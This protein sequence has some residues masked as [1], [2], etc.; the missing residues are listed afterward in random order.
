MESEQ[1][2][3]MLTGVS[4]GPSPSEQ[5]QLQLQQQAAGQQHLQ[6]LAGEQL[7][8]QVAQQLW[9]QHLLMGEQLQQQP[10][11]QQH[12]QLLVREQLPPQLTQQLWQQHLPKGEQ[13]QQRLAGQHL[14]YH[15]RTAGGWWHG[16]RE[17]VQRPG[18]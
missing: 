11:E 5:Q 9:Q 2:D 7:P 14:M 10:A 4:E 17:G 13:L 12:P 16:L 1:S 3:A 15:C 6:L 8:P 18:V